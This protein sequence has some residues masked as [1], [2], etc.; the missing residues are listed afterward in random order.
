MFST[1][2][3]IKELPDGKKKLTYP[4]IYDKF[5]V[6]IGFITDYASIPRVP[7]IYLIFNDVANRPAV[8]HDYLYSNS[9]ISRKYADETFLRAMKEERVPNWKAKVMYF[10]VRLFG[11]GVRQ[12]AYGFIKE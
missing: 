1:D 3:E 7:L 10:A 9:T 8:L 4:L 2:L 5:L 6:P 12:Q 11:K